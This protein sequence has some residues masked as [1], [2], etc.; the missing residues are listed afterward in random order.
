[1]SARPDL[2]PPSHVDPGSAGSGEMAGRPSSTIQVP[3]WLSEMFLITTGSGFPEA[4][5]QQLYDL[6]QQW[7]DAGTALTGLDPAVVAPP[8]APLPPLPAL[9][10]PPSLPTT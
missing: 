4:N 3:P 1:M 10:P 9:A 7:F 6:A 5:E 8:T 2:P